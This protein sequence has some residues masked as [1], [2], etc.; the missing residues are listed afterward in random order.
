M[1]GNN[2]VSQHKPQVTKITTHTAL[3]VTFWRSVDIASASIG[4]SNNS[5]KSSTACSKSLSGWPAS[6]QCH[7]HDDENMPLIILKELLLVALL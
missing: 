7:A 2:G 3:S 6:S 4:D 5:D 1:T